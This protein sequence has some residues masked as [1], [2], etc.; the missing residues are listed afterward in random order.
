M[1]EFPG[2]FSAYRSVQLG[3]TISLGLATA[4]GPWRKIVDPPMESSAGS[5]WLP[6]AQDV[7]CV[8]ELEADLLP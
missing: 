6:S 3:L 1:M 2:L 7:D 8:L 5:D 4:G